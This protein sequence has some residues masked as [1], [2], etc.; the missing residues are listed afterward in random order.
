MSPAYNLNEFKEEIIDGKVYYMSPSASP[1][2]GRIIGNIYFI[3]KSY[4]KGK[5]CEVFTDTIDV[6]LNEEGTDKVIPDVSIL[7]DPERFTDK[8]YNGVPSLIV[9]VISPTS[10]KRDRET[11]FYKYE[12]YGVKEYWIVD[13]LNKS[14]EQ[15]VLQDG[16][17]KLSGV[18]TQLDEAEK[19]RLHEE[20]GFV[21]QFKTTIF[22][23]LVI[24][25]DDIF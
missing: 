19:E 16:K 9:E 7:C 25:I 23:E 10:I 6:F 11:K 15:F 13:P 2:H 22:P 20:Q 4:L 24:D 5:T 17:Y 8:G 1:R 3:F 12:A 18:Y 21:K 14:I